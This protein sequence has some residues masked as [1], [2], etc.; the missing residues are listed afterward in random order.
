MTGR[1]SLRHG[2][3]NESVLQDHHDGHTRGDNDSHNT[4]EV[5]V[6]VVQQV[7]AVVELH[8]PS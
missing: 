4:S 1:P 2:R 3:K 8:M 7:S 6:T 5:G